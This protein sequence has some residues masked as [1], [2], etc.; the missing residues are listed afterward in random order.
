MKEIKLGEGIPED[1]QPDKVV[2]EAIDFY[3]SFKS[4]SVLLLEDTRVAVDKFRNM[5]NEIDF[6]EVDDK[7]KPIYPMNTVLATIKQVPDLVKALDEAE[8]S[9]AAEI[10]QNDKVRGA[11]TKS[12]YEDL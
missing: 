9:I 4:S 10:A 1:W 5:L 8:R 12:V 6:K 11:Q 2:K 7:G 3:N